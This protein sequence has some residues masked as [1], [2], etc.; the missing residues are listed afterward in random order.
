M[1]KNSEGR[2]LAYI[3]IHTHTQFRLPSTLPSSLPSLP[4]PS[5][6]DLPPPPTSCLYVV[7][8]RRRSRYTIRKLLVELPA[9]AQCLAMHLFEILYIQGLSSTHPRS[10]RF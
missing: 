8:E 2:I 10:L 5:F 4:P 6:L 1:G 9:V 3:Y 7:T